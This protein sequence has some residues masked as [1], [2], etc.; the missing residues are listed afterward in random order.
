MSVKIGLDFGT[1]FT[2]ICVED[3]KDKRNRSYSFHKFIDLEG[4]PSLVFPSVVQLNKDNT[5]S[6]GF[7]D[8]DNAAMVDEL[9]DKDMPKKPVEPKYRS[10]KQIPEPNKPVA[11]STGNS[12]KRNII[13]DF[14]ELKQAL[15]EKQ[16]QAAVEQYV[17]KK[18]ELYEKAKAEYERECRQRED[19]IA[20]NKKEV[21][22]ENERLRKNYES[23]LQEWE[24]FVQ[25]KPK[26]IPATYRSFKQMVFSNGFDWR[27]DLD[28]M[29][30]SVWYLC[31][32]FFDLDRE[33]GTQNLIVSMG[34]SS[35]QENWKKN[36]EKATQIILAVYDLI[37]NVFEHDRE[38]FLSSS[39]DELRR[40]TKIKAFSQSDKDD[41]QI[42]IFPE[43]F[44]NLN[45]LAKQKRFGTGV[46]AVVDIGGG[47]T[48]ISVFVAPNGKE[49][50]VFD[51][52]S[53][54]F[55]VNAIKEK[56]HEAHI[57][58]VYNKMDYFSE[59]I[60]NY[61]QT[62]GVKQEE[63]K[64][65]VSQR[66][67]VFT[68]GGSLR[69]ELRRSYAGFTDVIHFKREL[70]NYYSIENAMEI[71]EK[72]PLLSTALG[73]AFCDNDDSKIP[74]ISYRDLF[75]IVEEA[76]KTGTEESIRRIDDYDD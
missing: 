18:Q 72:I 3:S 34:T 51:Y 20:Q 50:K 53:I 39:L 6:Y 57:G 68:G 44:A 74:M 69:D 33:Y 16:R 15:M 63:A 61:A 1:H 21:D 31:Y 45:P 62:I 36:K 30:V 2:K 64:G 40:V 58:A 47:T 23:K 35:G 5:L 7:V 10:Y 8:T 27:F 60:K 76:Y 73:L 13:S 14:S 48:D 24:E 29:L 12:K 67:I 42:Y 54:P 56:G 43:S 11:P 28:P 41:N 59:K 52:V 55:G 65:V 75:E 49:M 70:M 38:L 22:A 37:E 26:L 71:A 9:L 19:A 32:V 46:N 66:P 4:N 17:Q 25:R